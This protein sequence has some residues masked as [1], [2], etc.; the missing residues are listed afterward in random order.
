[1]VEASNGDGAH[2][3]HLRGLRPDIAVSDLAMSG[4]FRAII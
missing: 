2:Q 4:G 1:M 3:L